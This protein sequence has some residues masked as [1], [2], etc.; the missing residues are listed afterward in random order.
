MEENNK[1]NIKDGLSIDEAK[2]SVLII[3]CI[4]TFLFALI[5]YVIDGDISNN[6]TDL[7]EI[8]VFVIGGVNISNSIMTVFSKR[9]A[10]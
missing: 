10:K 1:F 8:L 2:V 3:L 5:M 6:L 7:L 9:G 4:L